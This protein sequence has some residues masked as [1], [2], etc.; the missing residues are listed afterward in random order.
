MENLNYHPNLEEFTALTGK[1]NV[2]PVMVSV[3]VSGETPVST[4][5]KIND[6]SR[7]SFLFES[8]EGGVK[9]GR[10]SFLGVGAKST[11]R[12][13]G[14]S[15]EIIEDGQSKKLSGNPFNIFRDYMSSFNVAPMENAPRFAGGALG[16]AGYDMV[17]HFEDLPETAKKDLDVYDMC[18]ILTDT[19]LVFDRQ[20]SELK[21]IAMVYV[22]DE[23]SLDKEELYNAGI[24][25]I[26]SFVKKINSPMDISSKEQTKNSN[27]EVSSNFKKED[28]CSSVEKI[29]EYIRAGDVIQTVISQRFE[30]ENN[31]DSFDIYQSLRIVNPSPYMFYLNLGDVTVTGSSP[32]VLVRVEGDDISVR[33][34]A[35]TRPRGKDEAE[36]VTLEKELLADPKERAEH[37]MLVDLGRNDVGRVAESGSVRVDELMIVERYSHVMHIVSNV[38]AKMKK[39]LT[40]YDVFSSCFPAGTLSGAPKIRAMEIIEELEPCRRGIYGGAVGYFDFAGNMDMCI[41]IRTVVVYEDKIFVQAGAGIVAD[42]DPEKEFEETINKASGILKSVTMAREGLANAFDD[43]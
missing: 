37:I 14:D 27:N 41:T 23:K 5:L 33:P 43:R 40:S 18:F 42:S 26:D 1:F 3:E 9:W 35:G 11:I 21:I 36:D 28:F 19:M 6:T 17:R 16:Y 20:E 39:G 31:V 38:C 25:K 7:E 10:Y 8:V 29:K 13:K 32:E 12:S 4:F 30:T 22:D 34:I 2:V 15:V 24:K